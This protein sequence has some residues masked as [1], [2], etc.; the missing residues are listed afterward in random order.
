MP[1]LQTETRSWG[2]AAAEELGGSEDRNP[3]KLH[4]PRQPSV[5]EK[6]SS[7]AQGTRGSSRRGSRR[8]ASR[9]QRPRAWP[10]PAPT[11]A[12]QLGRPRHPHPARFPARPTSPL[13]AHD[14]LLL[15]HKRGPVHQARHYG[16]AQAERHRG[17]A[18]A[19]R[20][21]PGRR[22]RRRCSPHSARARPARL[23][24]AAAAAGR[25][26]RPGDCGPSRGGPSASEGP[27]LGGDGGQARTGM[28]PAGSG[29]DPGTTGRR[30][31]RGRGGRTRGQR[32]RA[33][34]ERGP[35]VSRGGPNRRRRGER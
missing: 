24:A 30:W 1:G 23:R 25:G 6:S 11:R 10:A 2:C 32:G 21:L 5:R 27:G 12:S 31:G 15:Q 13:G 22:R 7:G 17:G 16:H 33:Q 14:A 18:R 19:A 34:V 29:R 8:A 26:R 28:V 4:R 3:I 35:D 9:T 20:P